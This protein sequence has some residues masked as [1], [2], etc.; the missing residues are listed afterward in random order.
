[1]WFRM[2]KG[3]KAKDYSLRVKKGGAVKGTPHRSLT[4]AKQAAEVFCT[5]EQKDVEVFGTDKEGEFVA[6]VVATTNDIELSENPRLKEAYARSLD[7]ALDIKSRLLQDFDSKTIHAI[8]NALTAFQS[9]A[10]DFKDL[11]HSDRTKLSYRVLQK[12][13]CNEDTFGKYL[14]SSDPMTLAWT[15]HQWENQKNFEVIR[16]ITGLGN[17]KSDQIVSTNRES[18]MSITVDGKSQLLQIRTLTIG[19]LKNGKRFLVIVE[20]NEAAHA[21]SY[22]PAGMAVIAPEEFMT[23]A[24]NLVREEL[25]RHNIYRNKFILMSGNHTEVKSKFDDTT[26]ADMIPIPT[27]KAALDYIQNCVKQA[28]LLEKKGLALKEGLLIS[29]QPG[30]GK[31]GSIKVSLNELAGMVTVIVVESRAEI[32]K[33]YDMAQ[34]LAPA[35]VLLEDVDMLGGDRREGGR[36]MSDLLGV[37]SGTT[38]YKGVITIATTNYP[39]LIDEAIKKRA[40]R[41]SEH[42]KV[43]A[44]T[45]ELK[46]KILDL[47][48][49]KHV[50]PKKM[51][52]DVHKVFAPL[53]AVQ[54]VGD[55]IEK[56]VEQ[57]IKRATV[58]NRS[59]ELADFRPGVASLKTVAQQEAK[60]VGFGAHDDV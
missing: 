25:K 31:S 18:P 2:N 39:H 54:S 47:Y 27:L 23:E 42:V 17:P 51:W 38:E 44:L 19:T 1:M 55:H 28:H 32:R 13:Y 33:I 3:R 57:A 15:I 52:P 20:N 60:A 43:P 7:Q 34:S 59:I 12:I 49:K 35:I 24:V 50:V 21:Y 9:M 8:A 40:G 22:S 45:S 58:L 36:V 26:W 14:I 11:G 4:A 41:F 10:K 46:A 29:G 53:G 48:L 30:I 56:F 6:G 37:L 16:E 5:T